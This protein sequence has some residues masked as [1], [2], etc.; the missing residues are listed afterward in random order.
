MSA[1]NIQFNFN[2]SG[3]ITSVSETI[4]QNSVFCRDLPAHT[5]LEE[6]EFIVRSFSKGLSMVNV[7]S[8]ALKNLSD[9]GVVKESLVDAEEDFLVET[10]K[11]LLK[12]CKSLSAECVDALVELWKTIMKRIYYFHRVACKAYFTYLNLSPNVS[13]ITYYILNLASFH[14]KLQWQKY[15]FFNSTF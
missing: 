7:A 1:D 5:T 13:I 3:G 10:R 2:T 12:K 4:D 11:L 15:V 9:G 8:G 6:K 14:H